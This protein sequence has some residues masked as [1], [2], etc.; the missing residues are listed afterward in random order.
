MSQW[1]VPRSC[2]CY[3]RDPCA[4]VYTFA[5]FN[6]RKVDINFIS[7]IIRLDHKYELKGLYEEAVNYLTSF[8]TTSFDMWVDNRNAVY[9]RPD[10]AHAIRAINLARLTNTPSILPTAFYTCATLGPDLVHGFLM[11]DSDLFRERLTPDDLRLCLEL[12]ARLAAENARA[13]FL[14]FRFP[15]TQV[16]QNT[17]SQGYC[18]EVWRRILEQAGVANEKVPHPVA[19]ERALDSWVA[20]ADCVPATMVVPTPGNVMLV[21]TF[22]Q[23][24]LCAGCRNHLQVR[25]REVRRQVWSRLPELI[26][27]TIENWDA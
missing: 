11:S 5:R 17:S 14:L 1:A 7:A 8:Y 4:Q 21:P 18:A 27:L 26:G 20:D 22:P 2:L 16:C 3:S 10:P 6:G 13:A 25:D 9:W 12:K 24:T 23:R 19:S 15:G